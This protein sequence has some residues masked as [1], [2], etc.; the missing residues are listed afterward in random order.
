MIK[1]IYY[2][3]F[4][5]YYCYLLFVIYYLLFIIYYLL[6]IINIKNINSETNIKNHSNKK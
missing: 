6:F 2:L 5:I 4:V 1:I 3:L